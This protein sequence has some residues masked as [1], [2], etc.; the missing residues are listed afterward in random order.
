MSKYIR[1]DKTFRA[2][3]SNLADA[4]LKF[5]TAPAKLPEYPLHFDEMETKLVGF[6]KND[7]PAN[8]NGVPAYVRTIEP[9]E[10]APK[11]KLPEFVAGAIAATIVLLLV[12][13]AAYL[14]WRIL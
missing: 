9:L 7:Y 2:Q 13:G 14:G 10:I 11:G 4:G 12:A 5:P 8:F 3:I 6:S 1:D